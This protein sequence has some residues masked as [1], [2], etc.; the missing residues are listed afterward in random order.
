MEE[1]EN[2]I[3]KKLDYTYILFYRYIE[4]I[5]TRVSK[6]NI[7]DLLQTINSYKKNHDR[8]RN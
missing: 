6:E 1:L 2:D 4:D 3:F 5:F 7:D 8:E